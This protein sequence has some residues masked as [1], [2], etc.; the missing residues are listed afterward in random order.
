M[1]NRNVELVVYTDGVDSGELL[2]DLQHACDEERTT[3]IG[4]SQQLKQGERLRA[5]GTIVCDRFT[6]VFSVHLLHVAVHVVSLAVELQ[7]CTTAAKISTR[8]QAFRRIEERI[9]YR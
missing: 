2:N 7:R 9:F 6:G 3:Q 5:T 8:R 1:E 4:S